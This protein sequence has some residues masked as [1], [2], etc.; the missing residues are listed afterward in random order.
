MDPSHLKQVLE[1]DTLLL[2]ACGNVV[3]VVLVV[4]VRD[5][6]IVTAA[7][8]GHISRERPR[9]AQLVALCGL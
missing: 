2:Y 5:V 1:L 3:Y 6:I 7:S 8:V 4:I 9:D